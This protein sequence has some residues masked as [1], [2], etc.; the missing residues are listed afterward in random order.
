MAEL[1]K[2]ALSF[3]GEKL[4]KCGFKKNGI[5]VNTEE[6]KKMKVEGLSD[7]YFE[8]WQDVEG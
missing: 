2:S 7:R 4:S 5:G 3:R 6:C 1:P 8:K